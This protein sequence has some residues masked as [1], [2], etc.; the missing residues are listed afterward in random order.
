M[1]RLLVSISKEWR[2]LYRDI[3]GVVIVFFM[4]VILVIVVA[5]IQQRTFY[6]ISDAKVPV[7]VA[8]CDNNSIGEQIREGINKTGFFYVS[9]YVNDNSFDAG[10]LEKVVSTG[11]FQ[12]GVFIPEGATSSLH[13]DIKKNLQGAGDTIKTNLENAEVQLFFDPLVKKTTRFLAQSTLQNI[14][15]ESEQAIKLALY[16]KKEGESFQEFRAFLSPSIT[17]NDLKPPDKAVVEIPDSVQHSVPAW[18]LFGMFLICVP[19]AGNIIKE[20]GEGCLARLKTI[21]I[22]YFQI[23]L[24]K[25]IVFVG[26]C[27]L[28]ASLMIFMGFVLMPALGLPQLSVNGNWVLLILVALSS[29]FAATSY[30]VLLGSASST[31]MQASAFGAISTVILAALGGAWVPVD[32]MPPVMQKISMISPINWG[33]RGFYKVFMGETT[34]IEVLPFVS[35]LITFSLVSIMVS[36]LFRNYQKTM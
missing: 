2:L 14:L 25:A 16:N 22:T 9:A 5:L 6:S 13:N 35:L 27:L 1:K 32:V 26:I 28:Q 11:E 20:R 29:A 36:V 7:F 34:L 4:P 15:Y 23:M 12:I 18:I 21:P 17:L 3:E 31:Y 33:I 24:S 19:L 10:S 30:G 8:D